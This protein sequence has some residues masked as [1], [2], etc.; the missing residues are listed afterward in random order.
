MLINSFC[1]IQ[2]EAS[3]KAISQ[4]QKEKPSE[5]TSMRTIAHQRS[6]QEYETMD[7]NFNEK[8]QGGRKNTRKIKL[9]LYSPRSVT[10]TVLPVTNGAKG[11]QF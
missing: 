7:C 4:V 9:K 5:Y 11:H 6:M 10:S 1:S 8:G 2:K 3:L